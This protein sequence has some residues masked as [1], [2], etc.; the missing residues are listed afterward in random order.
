[1]V[2]NK[3]APPFRE[4][5]FDI[6]Y[7]QGISRE[8]ELLDLA[9]KLDIIHKSGAWFY[10]NDAR[11]GQGR[12]NVKQYLRDN[13]A[14]AD[15]IEQ[16]LRENKAKLDELTKPAPKGA[17][18]A[19]ATASAAAAAEPE[20]PTPSSSVPAVNIDVEVDDE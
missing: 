19:V 18:R 16:K 17:K 12:D 14:F 3:V 7:G 4:A 5:E 13:P 15:E 1:M 11:L 6:M 20:E 8:G 9:V 2:K 10:Y